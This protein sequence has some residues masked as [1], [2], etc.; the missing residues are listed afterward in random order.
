[1]GEESAPVGNLEYS[2]KHTLTL[3]ERGDMRPNS[4]DRYVF[5]K[6]GSA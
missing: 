2:S 5:G 1:M 6:D 4:K 3:Y